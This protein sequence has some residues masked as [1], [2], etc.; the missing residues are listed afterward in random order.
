MHNIQKAEQ[1]KKDKNYMAREWPLNLILMV[2]GIS[3]S[4]FIAWSAR[5]SH[6]TQIH[7]SFN[8][9]AK[10]DFSIIENKMLNYSILYK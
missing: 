6:E 8:N 5:V 7:Q 4:F 2:I 3:L 1:G 9:L 10:Q